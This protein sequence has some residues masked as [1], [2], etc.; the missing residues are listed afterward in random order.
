MYCINYF[1]VNWV[2]HVTQ[3]NFALA[4]LVCFTLF[5]VTSIHRIQKITKIK[6]SEP[7]WKE[8]RKIQ[9]FKAQKTEKSS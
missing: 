5:T 8:T 7:W 2:L 9:L 4:I 6:N 1:E 3:K